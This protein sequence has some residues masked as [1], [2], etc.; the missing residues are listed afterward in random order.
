[1]VA[2]FRDLSSTETE[3]SLSQELYDNLDSFFGRATCIDISK[4]TRHGTLDLHALRELLVSSQI[5]LSS[6]DI[7]LLYTG[8]HDRYYNTSRWHRS[9]PFVTYSA[10]SYLASRG[11]KGLCI[12]A[13]SPVG[14]LPLPRNMDMSLTVGLCNLGHLCSRDFVY[15]GFPVDVGY[16]QKKYILRAMAIQAIL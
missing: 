11:L 14:S 12:D 13:P 7:L 4:I 15:M 6:Y 10:L 1:M 16:P 8:H 9:R 3:A 5:D 2:Y